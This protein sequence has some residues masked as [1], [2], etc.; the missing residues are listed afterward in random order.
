MAILDI[1]FT[2]K[3]IQLFELFQSVPEVLIT[4]VFGV[5]FGEFGFCTYIY[6]KREEK[7]KLETDKETNE[8]EINE[9]EDGLV[10]DDEGE[11]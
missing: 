9:Q 11:Y 2:I 5:T 6:K 1:I 10:I 3:M 8:E 7:K 4:M